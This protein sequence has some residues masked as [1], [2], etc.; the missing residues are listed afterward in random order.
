LGL[1]PWYLVP[2]PI[3][4]RGTLAGSASSD[5]ETQQQALVKVH[6]EVEE[7]PL[8]VGLSRLIT[9]LGQVSDVSERLPP[10]TR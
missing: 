6:V 3:S 9:A 8:P 10:T 1:A 5:N 2:E 7:G 4:V